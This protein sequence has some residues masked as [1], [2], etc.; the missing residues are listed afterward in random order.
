MQQ[1]LRASVV[2]VAQ[3]ALLAVRLE[4]PATRTVRDYLPGGAIEA[5]ET[6]AQ[7][8]QRETLEETGYVVSVEASTEV[9]TRYPFVWNGTPYDCTTH[10]FAARLADA[11]AKPAIVRDASYHRGVVWVPAPE[12]QAR[13]AFD[14]AIWAAMAEVLR[15][16]GLE[17]PSPETAS[18]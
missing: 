1:R 11:D 4:D 18:R 13:F 14:D 7:A 3:N 9:V 5:G 16:W 10:Y 2:C 17:G 8:A 6:P 15:F 12:I